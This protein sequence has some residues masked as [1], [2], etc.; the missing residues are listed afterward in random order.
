MYN[1]KISVE[2]KEDLKRIYKYGVSKFGMNQADKYYEALFNH[3]EL[4]ARRPLSFNSVDHIRKDYRRCPCGSNSIYYKIS[5][6]YVEIMAIIGR[7]DL[8]SKL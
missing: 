8:D 4:I 5:D 3:F 2:T 1:Y 7:Q 6:N